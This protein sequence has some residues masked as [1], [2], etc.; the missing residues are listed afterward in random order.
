MGIP[1]QTRVILHWWVFFFFF[2]YQ[3]YIKRHLALYHEATLHM[4][5]YLI[6]QDS[7][8]DKSNAGSNASW[9]SPCNSPT[10]STLKNHYY[11]YLFLLLNYLLLLMLFVFHWCMLMLCYY[12]NHCYNTCYF[13]FNPASITCIISRYFSNNGAYITIHYLIYF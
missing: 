8:L 1:V 3:I 10:L 13:L 5:L 4:I 11:Y 7:V 9:N 6:G 2:L 12:K